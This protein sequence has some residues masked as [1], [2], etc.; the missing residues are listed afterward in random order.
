MDRESDST[1]VQLIERVRVPLETE[2]WRMVREGIVEPNVLDYL[3]VLHLGLDRGILSRIRDDGIEKRAQTC[4]EM[5]EQAFGDSRFRPVPDVFSPERSSIWDSLNDE[6]QALSDESETPAP[7]KVLIAGTPHLVTAWR[8]RIYEAS[9]GK[10]AADTWQLWDLTTVREEDLK[11]LLKNGPWDLLVEVLVGPVEDR[12]QLLEVLAGNIQ[13]GGQ[14]WVH[15]LNLPATVAV[16]VVPEELVAIGFGGL[17][18][19]YGEPVLEL[20]LPRNSDASDLVRAADTAV[21]LGFSPFE[22]ADEPGGVGARLM[23]TLI[24]SSSYLVRE[25]YVESEGAADREVKKGLNLEESPF[26]LADEINLDTVEGV[27]LGLR[28]HL[29]E[30]RYRLCPLLTM[31]IEAGALGRATDAGFY[32]A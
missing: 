14:V 8:D 17:P 1:V 26:M 5:S 31:R 16:Q 23:A 10:I 32:L 28:A 25:G 29:G 22:V 27:I 12:R 24:N 21:A 2:A 18:N 9:Q 7:G 11:K 13:R 6:V 3:S 15:T 30:D 4:L 19:R 20:S